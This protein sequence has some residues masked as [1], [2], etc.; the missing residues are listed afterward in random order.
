[1]TRGR[2]LEVEYTIRVSLSAGSLASDVQ[3]ILPIRIINFLSIDPPPSFPLS[4]RENSIPLASP[5]DGVDITD[6]Y[7]AALTNHNQHPQ[8]AVSGIFAPSAYYQSSRVLGPVSEDE[9]EP[10]IPSD[11]NSDYASH[12]ELSDFTDENSFDEAYAALTTEQDVDNNTDSDSLDDGADLG[13]LSMYDDS[14]NV[15]QHAITAARIDTEYGENAPRFAD[16]YY[17]SVQKDPSQPDSRTAVDHPEDQEPELW[18]RSGPG[19]GSSTSSNHSIP[20]SPTHAELRPNSRPPNAGSYESRP[21]CPRG[22]SSFALRVQEKLQAATCTID[23]GRLPPQVGGS[24]LKEKALEGPSMLGDSDEARDNS[25]FPTSTS[26]FDSSGGSYFSTRV[27][28]EEPG[29]LSLPIERQPEN[30]TASSS[31]SSDS[32][33]HSANFGI[34][35]VEDTRHLDARLPSDNSFTDGEVNEQSRTF[36]F[37]IG[38]SALSGSGFSVKP[39]TANGSRLL[40]RPPSLPAM[41]ITATDPGLASSALAT[42][43][44]QEIVSVSCGSQDKHT[45]Y[46]G[47]ALSRPPFA[48]AAGGGGSMSS[49]KDKIRELEERFRAEESKGTK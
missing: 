44:P 13:N 18:D 4:F 5:E 39:P 6:T 12:D 46:T 28:V 32:G 22:P 29:S 23:N 10:P 37:R 19:D 14:D 33:Y 11:H 42:V 40:P 24:N 41:P 21:S 48:P 26:V 15:V 9:D 25:N 7:I 49:V 36:A 30:S 8:P 27:G 31:G 35:H 20:R 38:S 16:L 34:E 3:V 2:L 1:M 17:A 43:H 45:A 47:I